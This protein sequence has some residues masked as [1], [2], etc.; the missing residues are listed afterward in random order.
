MRGSQ[1]SFVN[2]PTFECLYHGTRG[3]GKTTGLI[4]D[5]LQDVGRGH[6]PAWRGVLLRR[7][8]PELEDVRVKIEEWCRRLRQSA[9]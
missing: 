2:C 4:Q 3:P 1:V 6:G 5:F 8:Y 7:S 9:R